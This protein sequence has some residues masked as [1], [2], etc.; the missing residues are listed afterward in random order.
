MRKRETL[1]APCLQGFS[2]FF[3]F[4]SVKLGIIYCI[5]LFGNSSKKFLTKNYNIFI[6]L[7]IFQILKVT[8]FTYFQYYFLI[9]F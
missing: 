7:T 9:F 5:H 2:A 6:V 1:S 3:S 8:I 4:T